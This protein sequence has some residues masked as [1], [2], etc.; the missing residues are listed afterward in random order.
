MTEGEKLREQ[1]VRIKK[2]VNEEVEAV[3]DN[4]MKT[5]GT[6]TES[7]LKIAQLNGLMTRMDWLKKTKEAICE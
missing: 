2:K 1:S 3:F 5:S 7:N 4:F 6:N